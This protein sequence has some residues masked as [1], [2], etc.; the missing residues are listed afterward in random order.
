MDC[1]LC[2][3]IGIKNLT[4]YEDDR[5]AVLLL[6]KGFTLGHL[7]VV[8]K[9]H[10]SILEQV[11]DDLLNYMMIVAN[12]FASILFETLGLHGTNIL[13]QNGVDAGQSIP[14][15]SIDIIPRKMNDGVN[16]KWDANKA[17]H[18]SLEGMKEILIEA[19]DNSQAKEPE[20]VEEKPIEEIKSNNNEDDNYLIKQLRH[21]P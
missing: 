5:I 21:I 9:K 20:Q 10:I 2:K 3:V 17:S 6:T 12:K 8:P 4:V 7:K 18:E 1:V 13:V 11:D 19:L 16:L 15:F 14:H